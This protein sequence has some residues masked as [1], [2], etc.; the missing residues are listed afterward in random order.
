MGGREGQPAA[1]E[2]AG[3]QVDEERLA[4]VVQRRERLVEQYTRMEEA[5]AKAQSQSSVLTNS[6]KGLQGS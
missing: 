4:G 3:Q 2:V 1:F 6:I 5:M